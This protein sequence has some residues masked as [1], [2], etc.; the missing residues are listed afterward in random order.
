MFEKNNNL[1][2]K[3]LIGEKKW[4]FVFKEILGM[5]LGKMKEIVE[6]YFNC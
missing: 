3:V 4:F 2:V 5:V 6:G 1:Y